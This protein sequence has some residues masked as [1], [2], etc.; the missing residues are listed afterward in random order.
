V[1]RQLTKETAHV[2]GIISIV[3]AIRVYVVFRSIDTL[4]ELLGT[5]IDQRCPMIS[6]HSYSPDG[7]AVLTVYCLLPSS[8]ES[9]M[10]T[11]LLF[12]YLYTIVTFL[13]GIVRF[14][15]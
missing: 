2:T 9:L 4:L 8:V 5:A 14:S 12:V 6:F 13:A 3:F 11:P 1:I 7:A 15:S 10:K